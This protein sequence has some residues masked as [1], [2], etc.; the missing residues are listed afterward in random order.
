MIRVETNCQ[1]RYE[2]SGEREKEAAQELER[3]LDFIYR[4]YYSPYTAQ[5]ISEARQDVAKKYDVEIKAVV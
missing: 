1:Y 2:V 3:K 4:D 5:D